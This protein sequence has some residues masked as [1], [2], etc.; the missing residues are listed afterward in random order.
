M[1]CRSGTTARKGTGVETLLKELERWIERTVGAGATVGP[2]TRTSR[3]SS[4]SHPDT[5]PPTLATKPAA[6]DASATTTNEAA[7][8][9]PAKTPAI[10]EQQL[11]TPPSGS[12]ATTSISSPHLPPAASR[13]ESSPGADQ[14]PT[15]RVHGPLT[16]RPTTP[17]VL[18]KV[19]TPRALQLEGTS[20]SSATAKDDETQEYDD[21]FDQD[22]N[23]D[24]KKARRKSPPST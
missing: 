23:E 19:A 3:P 7:T 13:V 8:S 21:D 14:A 10:P 16:A 24:G 20:A 17:R 6:P 4:P 1:W 22:E 9:L 18:A 12:T 15:V 5:F 2:G 11:A